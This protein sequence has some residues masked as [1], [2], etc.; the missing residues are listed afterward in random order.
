MAK[1]NGQKSQ[2]AYLVMD[3]VNGHEL[4]DF[5]ANSGAFSEKECRYFFLQ[6]LQGIHHIHSKGYVHRDLKPE[7]ILVDIIYLS[8]ETVVQGE[9]WGILKLT[10]MKADFEKSDIFAS[11]TE[12]EKKLVNRL[13]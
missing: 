1:R 9:S 3:A 7:N 5:I 8:D 6:M 10:A 11:F 2:V 4:F 13:I 12:E